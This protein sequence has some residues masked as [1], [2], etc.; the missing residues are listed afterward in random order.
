MWA[1]VL[2][3][4]SLCSSAQREEEGGREAGGRLT[5][6]TVHPA[7]GSIQHPRTQNNH[8]KILTITFSYILLVVCNHAGNSAFIRPGLRYKQCW[9]VSSSMMG[10][11]CS[12]PTD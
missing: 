8:Q 5:G 3:L 7:A 4:L 10:F 6:L 12:L 2:V 11:V 9:H 1:A